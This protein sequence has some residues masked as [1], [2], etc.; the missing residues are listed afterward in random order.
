MKLTKALWIESLVAFAL[1]L[2]LAFY[3]FTQHIQTTQ[4]ASFPGVPAQVATTTIFAVG[5]QQAVPWFYGPSTASQS[6]C[7][8]RIISTGSQAIEINF[9]ATSSSTATSTLNLLL[10]TGHVQ[11][12]STTVA[13]DAAEYGCGYLGLK[14]E[15]AS[16]TIII[17]ETR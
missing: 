14:G 5:P 8:A 6:N 13:Y 17:T 15:I 7:S 1:L 11:S 9:G 10:I 16:S 2:G 3:S 4:G 12:A